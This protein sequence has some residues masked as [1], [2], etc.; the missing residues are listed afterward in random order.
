MDYFSSVGATLSN[1]GSAI[2]SVATT[3][4]SSISAA[5]TTAGSSISSVATTS[6]TS[7]T[8]L[9]GSGA[10]GG[11]AAGPEAALPSLP[12]EPKPLP[13]DVEGLR[14]VLSD[15]AALLLPSDGD[16][17][18]HARL[19]RQWNLDEGAF[20][21]PSAIAVPATEGDV[22]QL[23]KFAS[24]HAAK[25]LR[26]AVACGRHSHYSME[27]DSLV[28]DLTRFNTIDVDAEKLTAK[29]GGGCLLGNVDEAC[30][31]HG[32]GTTF[33]H[34]PSTGVGGLTLNGGHGFLQRVYGLA[35]DNLLSMRVVLASGLVVN[36]SDK[37]ARVL[38]RVRRGFLFVLTFLF[39]RTA[40]P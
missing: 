9:F 12:R 36:T 25:G 10:A 31:P 1:A 17:F 3:A 34:D 19:D 5:A 32:L 22:V 37:E 33:G 4:G 29:V 11:A 8:G 26:L 21:V 24:A 20:G 23:V 30:R 18:A 35:V 39:S 15:Q 27:N 38:A 6:V 16:A 14:K 13:G 7:V 40:A 28:V 2:S